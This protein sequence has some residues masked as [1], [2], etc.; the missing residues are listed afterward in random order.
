MYEQRW[1]ILCIRWRQH[2]CHP[3]SGE[4]EL[5]GNQRRL[6]LHMVWLIWVSGSAT[7]NV[8]ESL[9]PS[10]SMRARGP[11]ESGL[12]RILVCVESSFAD[13]TCLSGLLSVNK[14]ILRSHEMIMK[15]FVVVSTGPD[16]LKCLFNVSITHHNSSKMCY[17]ISIY[18]NAQI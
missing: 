3:T 2:V 17:F 18:L 16:K 9:A 15:L 4:A 6:T 13:P 7:A 8:S 1:K 5:F 10:N 12:L 14:K 11:V